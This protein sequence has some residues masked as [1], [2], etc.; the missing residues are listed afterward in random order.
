[1]TW[2]LRPGGLNEVV[3]AFRDSFSKGYR[4]DKF[5]TIMHGEFAS[6]APV[7]F[8]LQLYGFMSVTFDEFAAASF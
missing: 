3:D 6:E 2:E 8:A 5:F 7:S 4:T 1:M